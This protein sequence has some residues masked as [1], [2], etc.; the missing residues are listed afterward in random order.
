M[1]KPST[2][3]RRTAIQSVAHAVPPHHFL[4]YCLNYTSSSRLCVDDLPP[5]SARR[6]ESRWPVPPAP[7]P[8]PASASTSAPALRQ[9]HQQQ[10]EEDAAKEGGQAGEGP[11]RPPWQQSEEWD[12]MYGSIPVRALRM[13]SRRSTASECAISISSGVW[14]TWIGSG[15]SL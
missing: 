15:F 1:Q 14:M 10:E 8:A 12:R 3:S 6:V 11:S 4:F 2:Q 7:A 13:P 9:Q 5:P